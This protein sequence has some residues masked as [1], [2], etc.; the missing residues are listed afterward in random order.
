V[1]SQPVA[2]SELPFLMQPGDRLG[3]YVESGAFG[4]PITFQL[5]AKLSPLKI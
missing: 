4:T 5:Y 2:S 1:G 3:V